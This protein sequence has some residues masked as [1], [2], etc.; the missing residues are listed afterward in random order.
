MLMSTEPRVRKAHLIALAPL[1]ELMNVP[2]AERPV[3][4]RGTGAAGGNR[5][6]KCRP[7]ARGREGKQPQSHSDPLLN[8]KEMPPAS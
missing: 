3:Q 1:P 7:T 8:L 2:R 4:T 6:G 5:T